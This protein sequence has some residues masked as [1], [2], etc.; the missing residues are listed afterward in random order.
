MRSEINHQIAERFRAEG[1]LFSNAHRDYL[2]RMA[3]EAAAEAEAMAEEQAASGRC[4]TF[5][6][7]RLRPDAFGQP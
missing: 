3:D 5:L 1:I 7:P 6:S 2:K 4:R